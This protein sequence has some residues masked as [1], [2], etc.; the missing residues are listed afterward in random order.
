MTKDRVLKKKQERKNWLY[1]LAQMEQYLI[2][3]M[4]VSMSALPSPA[5]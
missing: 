4:K 5:H 2:V 1:M 3:V